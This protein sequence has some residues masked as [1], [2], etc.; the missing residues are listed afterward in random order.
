MLSPAVSKGQKL[1]GKLQF[2]SAVVPSLDAEYNANSISKYTSQSTWPKRN[3]LM[4]IPW[5]YISYKNPLQGKEKINK[6]F[7]K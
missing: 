4:E 2:I 7:I 5:E 3:T 1:K 6:E